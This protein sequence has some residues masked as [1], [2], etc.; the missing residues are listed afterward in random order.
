M[1]KNTAIQ[2]IIDLAKVFNCVFTCENG[3]FIFKHREAFFDDEPIAEIKTFNNLEEPLILEAYDYVQVNDQIFPKDI[4]LDTMIN[5]KGISISTELFISDTLFA[6]SARR[7][8]LF[9][10][11]FH[12]KKRFNTSAIEQPELLKLNLLDVILFQKTPSVI[13]EIEKR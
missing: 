12:V 13:V 4:D 9:L 7:I 6:A 10:K 3:K 2:T 11:R 1:S 8:F 5:P